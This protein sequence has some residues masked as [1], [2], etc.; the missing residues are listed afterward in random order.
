MFMRCLLLL[1]IVFNSYAAERVIYGDDN[2]K[3]LY[4]VNNDQYIQWA[5]ATAAMVRKND[6]TDEG[7]YYRLN[8]S[9]MHDRGV[10][11]YA[12]FSDQYSPAD[13]TAFLVAPDLMVTAGHCG[14]YFYDC[15]SNY[16]IFDYALKYSGQDDYQLIPKENVVSCEDVVESI[17]TSSSDYSLLKLKKAVTD[18]EPL[19]FR[20][21]GKISNGAPL[22]LIGHPSGLPLK[23]ADGATV[24]RNSN[25]DFFVTNTDSFAGNSGSPVINTDTGEVEGILVRGQ[26]DYKYG[27]KD[28]DG[29]SCKLPRVCKQNMSGC[30]GEDV[31]RITNIQALMN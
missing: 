23:V 18:R 5:R 1:F 24:Q 13:C 31:T 26:S 15:V 2:R 30:R 25:P 29:S 19:R 17:N 14:E 20:T 9:T 22:V 6:L 11:S 7:D 28:T 12:K 3:D 16:F 4:E 10:C 21:S 27:F 8:G